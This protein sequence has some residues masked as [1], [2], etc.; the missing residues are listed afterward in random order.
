MEGRKNVFMVVLC[1]L[2]QG[3]KQKVFEKD[4]CVFWILAWIFFLGKDF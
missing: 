1:L 4:V 2:G 3:S